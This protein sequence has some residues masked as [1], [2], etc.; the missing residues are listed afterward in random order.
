MKVTIITVC[1]NS[2]DTIEDTIKSVISQTYNNYE[3][4]V[5][6]GGSTD[7]T[8]KIISR[9]KKYINTF[10]S[11]KDV[12]IYD[13]INKGIKKSTGEIVSILHSDDT[14][15]D[16]KTIQ[17]VA[18]YFKSN[19][20]LDCLIGDTIIIKKNSQKVIRKY[21]ANFFNKWMLYIGFSPPHPST[22]IKKKI[23]DN[24]GFYNK[25]YTIAGDFD[26]FVRIFLKA[27]INFK[28]V[29]ENFVLMKYGGKSTV[30]I[31]SNFTS[32]KEMIKSL[33]ESNLYANWFFILLRF[34]I[35]LIQFIIK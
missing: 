1:F 8:N 24:Y 21:K 17:K 35:K 10:I 22:F 12:G 15:Y 25:N 2:Q 31:K 28:I 14:F 33:K 32:S 4:V 11:E 19:L 27:N 5:I 30:S 13:A 20:S 6:D 18:S 34:P 29:D 7:D 23:Y 16:N 9:Y 26:F 3:Y